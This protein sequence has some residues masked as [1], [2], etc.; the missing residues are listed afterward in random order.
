L[1]GGRS[2][3]EENSEFATKTRMPFRYRLSY[4]RNGLRV[5]LDN[6]TFLLGKAGRGLKLH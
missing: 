6:W 5:V 4:Y 1:R 2:D 3:Q